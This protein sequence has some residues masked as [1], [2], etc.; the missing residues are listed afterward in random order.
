MSVA[1]HTDAIAP[2]SDSA[3]GERVSGLSDNRLLRQLHAHLSDAGSGHEAVQEG[4]LANGAPDTHPRT[5][6]ATVGLVAQQCVRTIVTRS[7]DDT[8]A[9]MRASP[10]HIQPRERSAIRGITQNRSRAV[11]LIER[12]RS[13]IE[14]AS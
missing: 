9:R 6:P 11:K 3:L 8:A 5:L 10:A 2:R 4:C 7:T 12:K 1:S 13:A 14:N